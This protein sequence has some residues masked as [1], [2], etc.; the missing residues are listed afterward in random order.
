[1][2]N[3]IT[4]VFLKWVGKSE[5][6]ALVCAFLLL[7]IIDSMGIVGVI[8]VALGAI[9]G[10][11]ARLPL[12]LKLSSEQLVFGTLILFTIKFLIS[13]SINWYLAK[14]AA[15]LRARIM[16]ETFQSIW[17]LGALSTISLDASGIVYRVIQ[18]ASDVSMG[19]VTRLIRLAGDMLAGIIV[20][21]IAIWF[22]GASAAITLFA[23]IILF[24]L[25]GKITGA[26]VSRISRNG[27]EA[28]LKINQLLNAFHAGAIEN[29]TYKKYGFW[30]FLLEERIKNV[31]KFIQ[32]VS[33]LSVLPKLV[34]EYLLILAVLSY[35]AYQM[36]Q[37]DT[38]GILNL[39]VFAVI[40]ARLIPSFSSITSGFVE[41]RSAFE[42]VKLLNN[43]STQNGSFGD[44]VDPA[45]DFFK[46]R[47]QH[48]VDTQINSFHAEGLKLFKIG[49]KEDKSTE[50]ISNLSFQVP[51][52]S[53]CG[54]FGRSG[55]GK[56]TL[57]Y[58]LLNHYKFAKGITYCKSSN[59]TAIGLSSLNIGY[60]GV[61]SFFL[62]D[63][64]SK[65]IALSSNPDIARVKQSLKLS[66]F[67]EKYGINSQVMADGS[68]FSAGERQRL[69]LARAIYHARHLLVL[70]E[71]TSNLNQ[72]LSE[73]VIKNLRG[74]SVPVIAISHDRSLT[75]LFDEV[76]NIEDH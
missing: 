8:A 32:Q 7:S 14:F 16:I 68:N 40:G 27:M 12:N 62:E 38:S 71:P 48:S 39:T 28:G 76:I 26:G 35:A 22:S 49:A 34:Y 60:N 3:I 56:T 69:G 46:S 58:G 63:S 64:I 20:V 57:I 52:G 67:P 15:T 53:I 25:F 54:I 47:G 42:S 59:G 24:F 45:R 75:Q 37:N 36:F 11:V 18:L 10:E 4:N 70:D 55:S 30:S 41:V 73:E 72:N 44:A 6:I 61:N 50:L 2:R 17:R 19:F 65:N 33:F 74:L 5:A 9:G 43:L 51:T 21:A 29:F 31:Q 1:M 66:C 23:G 13:I